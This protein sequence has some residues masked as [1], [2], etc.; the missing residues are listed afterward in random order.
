METHKMH[1]EIKLKCRNAKSE[2]GQIG[3]L[4]I[5]KIAGICSN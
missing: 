5:S 4:E 1:P 3:S 2:R